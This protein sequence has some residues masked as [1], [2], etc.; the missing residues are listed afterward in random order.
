VVGGAVGS[1]QRPA[2]HD[3]TNR[4]LHGFDFQW[5]LFP[6]PSFLLANFLLEEK[7]P[8]LNFLES[9]HYFSKDDSKT[10]S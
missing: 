7:R 6:F 9:I 2:S 1:V 3:V 4:E 5:A 10:L 8:F